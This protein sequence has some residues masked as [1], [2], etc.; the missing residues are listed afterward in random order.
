M[1]PSGNNGLGCAMCRFMRAL[2]FSGI[3]AAVG[4]LTAK[5]L[6][7]DMQT[8]MLAAFFCALALV[9]KTSKEKKPR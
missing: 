9:V 1:S 8:I 5:W 2:A 7:A 4:G 6:G 3:G